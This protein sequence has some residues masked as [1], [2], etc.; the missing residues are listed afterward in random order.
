VYE[1]SHAKNINLKCV[2]HIATS[3]YG[4]FTWLFKVQLTAHLQYVIRTDELVALHDAYD[5]DYKDTIE[6]RALDAFSSGGI[7]T[8]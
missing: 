8:I 4:I 2:Q 7:F 1:Y 6:T 5:L 3:P